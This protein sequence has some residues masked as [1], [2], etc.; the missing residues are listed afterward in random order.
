MNQIIRKN[1]KTVPTPVG[2]YSHVTVIPPNSTLY[3]FSGQIGIDS[4][5][6]IPLS[7][8]KQVE[9]TFK[10]IEKVL[11]SENLTEKN[12]TKVNVWSVEE[13]NWDHFYAIWQHFFVVN[14]SM[15]IAYVS[16]LGLPEIKIEIEIFAAKPE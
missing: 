7:H 4:N 14:P 15:T 12:I 16:A 2:D 5:G 1:P 9:N 3:T 11:A 8:Q 13:I 10:N 6:E